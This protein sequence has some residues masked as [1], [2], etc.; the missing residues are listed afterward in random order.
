MGL[1]GPRR[2]VPIDPSH[3]VAGAVHPN[4]VKLRTHAGERRAVITRK[5]SGNPAAQRDVERAQARSRQRARSRPRGGTHEAKDVDDAPAHHIILLGFEATTPA[6]AP[7]SRGSQRETNRLVRRYKPQIAV[8]KNLAPLGEGRQHRPHETRLHTRR[9]G[10]ARAKRGDVKPIILERSIVNRGLEH[11]LRRR[12]NV[13]VRIGWLPRHKKLEY[14]L[15]AGARNHGTCARCLSDLKADR[16][17][18]S[19]N[20]R[21]LKEIERTRNG[22]ALGCRR[23]PDICTLLR[24][25]R[26]RREGAHRQDTC[27]S[28]HDPNIHQPACHC[29]GGPRPHAVTIARSLRLSKMQDPLTIRSLLDELEA[30]EC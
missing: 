25:T 18:G 2:H 13:G 30:D 22:L 9:L 28:R 19:W 12:R 29:R 6:V 21:M 3:I 26:G 7:T 27:S 14:S 11:A 15:G 16:N 4:L 1:A 8:L 20:L 10:H 5:R 23:A 17:H 24:P